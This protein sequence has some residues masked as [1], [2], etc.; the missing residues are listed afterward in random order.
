MPARR[1]VA[2][3]LVC[4]GVGPGACR[5]SAEPTSPAEP[6][7]LPLE[8]VV[9]AAA[10]AQKAAP[11][12]SCTPLGAFATDEIGP[13]VW[14]LSSRSIRQLSQAVRRATTAE[15]QRLA[16]L[17]RYVQAALIRRASA[18]AGAAASEALAARVTLG[19]R[20][21]A[22]GELTA[23]LGETPDSAGRAAWLK[24]AR[25]PL[26]A[27]A[28]TSGRWWN[29]LAAAANA[30]GLARLSEMSIALSPSPLPGPVERARHLLGASAALYL[31]ALDDTS[32]ARGADPK[33]LTGGDLPWILAPPRGAEA[34]LEAALQRV[35][36]AVGLGTDPLV[37]AATVYLRGHELCSRA[38][39]KAPSGAGSPIAAIA[40][41]PATTIAPAAAVVFTAAATPAASIASGAPPSPAEP[42]APAAPE[43]DSTAMPTCGRLIVALVVSA[44]ASE[45]A[46]L[47]QEHLER[48]PRD[49][50]ADT[51]R[52]LAVVRRDAALLVAAAD[53]DNEVSEE[54]AEGV[55]QA[56]VSQALGVPVGAGLGALLIARQPP[57]WCATQRVDGA[58]VAGVLE[59]RLESL[60]GPE[61]WQAPAA[62]GLL[63]ELAR[64]AYAAPSDI[65]RQLG[66]SAL[67]DRAFVAALARSLAEAE[68]NRP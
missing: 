4:L 52:L 67:D 9:S 16:A 42:G 10:A 39:D 40:S 54:A 66:R 12:L 8:A 33:I 5:R 34:G 45:P 15:S 11:Q 22:V 32:R 49:V 28:V 30:S 44:L 17:S 26:D 35:G 7:T 6:K 23:I 19:Q 48:A 38:A 53:L 25:V 46:W 1:L 47:A 65:L 21:I 24:A 36:A 59:S 55:L 63:R 58:L 37:D 57:F 2:A 18:A 64:P 61:W 51:A 68:G 13:Y 60:G 56:R 43:S 31:G 14:V 62:L 41:A 3:Y 50:V 20:Q 27:L 29:A